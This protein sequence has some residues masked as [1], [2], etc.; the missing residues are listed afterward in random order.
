MASYHF[1]CKDIGMN[2]QYEASAKKAEDLI[3]QIA[4]HAKT[5]HNITEINDDLKQKVNAAIKRR[6]F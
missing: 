3:P 2:C 5:A 1:K 4:E 6:L